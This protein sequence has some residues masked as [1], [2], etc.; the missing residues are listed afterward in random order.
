MKM[1]P[2]KLPRKTIHMVDGRVYFTDDNWITV[3]L[4]KRGTSHRMVLNKQEADNV[5]FLAAHGAAE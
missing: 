4:M 3:W 1:K 2:R 5:R